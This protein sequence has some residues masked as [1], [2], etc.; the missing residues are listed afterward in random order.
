MEETK[1]TTA[2]ERVEIELKELQEKLKKL[3]NFIE[4]EKFDK[5]PEQQKNL[6]NKQAKAMNTYAAILVS[7]LIIWED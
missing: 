1:Q 7:R 2:K 5:L 3:E 6:L 4:N